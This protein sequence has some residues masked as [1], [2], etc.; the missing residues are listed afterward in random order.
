MTSQIHPL[1]FQ[2]IIFMDLFI[3]IVVISTY[4]GVSSFSRKGT[5]LL[6]KI[7]IIGFVGTCISLCI[8]IFIFFST[9]ISD[10]ASLI[11]DIAP[12]ISCRSTFLPGT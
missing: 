8:N 6:K 4:F 5:L 2:T 7:Q 3:V 10:R 11:N 9:D 1:Q 12:F